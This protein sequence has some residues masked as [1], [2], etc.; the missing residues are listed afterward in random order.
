MHVDQVGSP[1]RSGPSL[2]SPLH[3]RGQPV[4]PA[5]RVEGVVL[6][7]AALAGVPADE[8]PVEPH[9]SGEHP[10]PQ[11]RAVG[12]VD[13]RQGGRADLAVRLQGGAARPDR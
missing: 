6:D 3:E 7:P 8:L 12:A 13:R 2:P 1:H 11:L 5:S 4:E 10:P 9:A